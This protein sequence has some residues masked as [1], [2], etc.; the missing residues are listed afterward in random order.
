V[1]VARHGAVSGGWSTGLVCGSHG[2]GLWK[3]IMLGWGSFNTHLGYR[4]GTGV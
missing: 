2:C 3:G 4:V 1:L